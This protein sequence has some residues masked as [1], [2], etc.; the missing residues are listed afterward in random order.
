MSARYT[1]SFYSLDNVLWKIDILDSTFTGTASDFT[2]EPDGFSLQYKGGDNRFDPI[3]GSSVKFSFHVEDATHEFFIDEVLT[4]PGDRFAIAIYKAGSLWWCGKIITKLGTMEDA[5]YPYIFQFTATDGLAELKDV[6]YDDNGVAYTGYKTFVE[7]LNNI[8]TK[9]TTE[10][11]WSQFAYFTRYAVHWYEKDMGIAETSCPMKHTYVDSD[12]FNEVKPSELGVLLW[13]YIRETITGKDCYYVLEHILS[14]WNCRIFLAEGIWN[15]VQIGEFENEPI[16]YVSYIKDLSTSVAGSKSIQITAYTR[17]KGGAIEYMP[18]VK[19]VEKNY[20]YRTGIKG[21]NTLL[22]QGDY[23]NYIDCGIVNSRVFSFKGNVI[24]TNNNTSGDAYYTQ[25]IIYVKAVSIST[26]DTYFLTDAISPIVYFGP[27]RWMSEADLIANDFDGHLHFNS[28]YGGMAGNTPLLSWSDSNSLEFVCP[29]I[30]GAEDDYYRIYFKMGTYDYGPGG[31]AHNHIG[32][33]Y[34]AICEGFE[35]KTSDQPEASR[36]IQAFNQLP[37]YSLVNSNDIIEGNETIFGDV[38]TYPDF[39]LGL[40]KLLSSG[41]YVDTKNWCIHLAQDYKTFNELSVT[42][43]LKGQKLPLAKYNGKIISSS[44]SPIN[45]LVWGTK[46]YVPMELT[47]TAAFDEWAGRWFDA[48]AVLS[49]TTISIVDVTDDFNV[50]IPL[51]YLVEFVVFENLT[52][53]TAQISCGSSATTFECFQS[54]A[55]GT[56]LNAVV[57]NKGFSMTVGTVIYFHHAGTGDSW[58]S[59][60]ANVHICLRKIE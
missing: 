45:T 20:S 21:D 52:A 54:E 15:I 55:M 57:V 14:A 11:L 60:T 1:N 29:E 27:I 28:E 39:G 38:W 32:A 36:K 12:V 33:V 24:R 47:F 16:K 48:K 8:L 41:N 30:E 44:Y 40:L 53:N 9:I 50:I 43:M 49:Y 46:V 13:P 31:V 17:A 23:L 18:M 25:F 22:D 56:N 3:I 51:G 34:S 35:L 5:Y 59:V 10:S 6:V 37:D 7:H 19:W 42:Q 58:N 2:T 4:E 26:G